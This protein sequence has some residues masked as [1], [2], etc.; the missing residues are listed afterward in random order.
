MSYNADLDLDLEYSADTMDT[1]EH[2]YNS[3]LDYDTF[4]TDSDVDSDWNAKEGK[5]NGVI[6]PD[7]LSAFGIHNHTDS[8]LSSSTSSDNE[9]LS[10]AA[11]DIV[12]ANLNSTD[13][14]SDEEPQNNYRTPREVEQLWSM[15]P[16]APGHIL[17]QRPPTAGPVLPIPGR[18]ADVQVSADTKRKRRFGYVWTT[19]DDKVDTEEMQLKQMVDISDL[20]ELDEM[21]RN[22]IQEGIPRLGYF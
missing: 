18:P 21:Q 7:D 13:M 14:D 20:K 6:L 4:G 17:A 12:Q 5:S 11:E 16:D 3:K 1:E 8:D 9:V 2:V 15:T 22:G 10:M 19:A